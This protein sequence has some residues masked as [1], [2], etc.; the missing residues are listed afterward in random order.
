MQASQ[1]KRHSPPWQLI[2][3]L[4]VTIV[5]IVA[6]YVAYFTGMG[7]PEDHVNNGILLEPPKS[8]EPLLADAEGEL[9]QFDG[10]NRV[11]RLLVPVPFPCEQVCQDHLYLTRQV[12]VRL[13]EKAERVE[14][15][16]VNFGG[17]QGEQ[18]LAQIAEAHPKL[19][20]FSVSP[21][22]WQDWLEDTNVPR[23]VDDDP[24]YLLVDQVG[25]AMMYYDRNNDGNQ[26]LKDVKRVLRFSPE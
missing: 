6:A 12:H 10:S 19:K 4:T 22:R 24:Y 3:I 13:G 8:L 25:F 16:A 9:P 15:Y 20:H 23:P 21:S 18:F 14:R 7:V 5:P 1:K 11:W 2:A 26:L 17:E